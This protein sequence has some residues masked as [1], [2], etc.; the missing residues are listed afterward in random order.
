MPMFEDKE[1]TDPSRKRHGEFTYAFYDRVAGKEYRVIRD[2]VNRWTGELPE[3]E[4]SK[5]VPRFRKLEEMKFDTALAEIV[6]H[7]AFLWLGFQVDVAPKMAGNDRNPDFLLRDS[8]GRPLAY[9]EVTSINPPEDEVARNNREAPI[10]EAL[11][12][13]DIPG[14]LRLMYDVEAFG[15]N[16][17]PIQQVRR[18]VAS[19][20]ADNAEEAR[21]QKPVEKVFVFGTWRLRL[22]LH[23]GFKERPGSRKIFMWGDINGRSMGPLKGLAE[24]GK[25]LNAKVRKYGDLSLPFLIVV[26]DRISRFGFLDLPSDVADAL[27]GREFRA[28]RVV[29]GKTVESR[30][31]RETLGWMGRPGR[32]R[33]TSAS[34]VMVF[35][36]CDIWRLGEAKYDPLLVHHPWAAHPLPVGMLP[37]RRLEMDENEGR[38]IPATSIGEILGLPQPWPPEN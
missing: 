9:A 36:H 13:V 1:R 10:F 4:I 31:I 17:I 16:S 8:T 6:M 5:I 27:F 26:F 35:P 20:A 7:A 15:H 18:E 38:V 2:L 25:V 24:L 32:P 23:A 37:F 3:A 22:L 12:Q 19:W 30:I 29:N 28:E 14:D 21:S 11:N 34:A 33:N